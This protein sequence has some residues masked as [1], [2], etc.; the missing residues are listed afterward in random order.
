M[1][2]RKYILLYLQFF[3]LALS[4]W[5]CFPMLNQK[6]NVLI[7]H[8]CCEVLC[9]YSFIFMIYNFI[10]MFLHYS[11]VH[12]LLTNSKDSSYRLSSFSWLID[13][14]YDKLGL[15]TVSPYLVLALSFPLS[16]F[17]K[18]ILLWI[19][20][21]IIHIQVIVI[22]S[23]HHYMYVIYMLCIYISIHTDSLIYQWY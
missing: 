6:E 17:K 23:D 7:Y 19:S 2:K 8:L 3:L 22:I 1:R 9:I 4:F 13:R 16:I 15:L 20:I 11:Q 18:K 12:I 5:M 14:K 21:K 10:F